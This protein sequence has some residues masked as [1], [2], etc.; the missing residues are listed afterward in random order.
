MLW[1]LMAVLVIV[2][3][4]LAFQRKRRY[5]SPRDEAWRASLDSD[6]ALEIEEIRRAE[7]EWLEAGGW[8]EPPE[9]DAWR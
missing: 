7:E 9:D 8:E 2:G 3:A 5:D 4:V 6:E 1:V